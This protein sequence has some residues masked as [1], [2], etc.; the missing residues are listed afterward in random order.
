MRKSL[1]Q[2]LPAAMS[3]PD[4]MMIKTGCRELELTVPDVAKAQSFAG[5]VSHGPSTHHHHHHDSQTCYCDCPSHFSECSQCVREQLIARV[6]RHDDSDEEADHRNRFYIVNDDHQSVPNDNDCLVLLKS[7]DT[8]G[9]NAKADMHNHNGG[10]SDHNLKPH[11][12]HDLSG[13]NDLDSSFVKTVDISR[14]GGHRVSERL[15]QKPLSG[16]KDL[17]QIRDFQSSIKTKSFSRDRNRTDSQKSNDVDIFSAIFVS[18]PNRSSFHNSLPKGAM[19]QYIHMQKWDSQG[20]IKNAN[21]SRHHSGDNSAKRQQVGV[22]N[23]TSAAAMVHPDSEEHH[24]VYDGA[25]LN[26]DENVF[27]DQDVVETAFCNS[28]ND[29]TA[30]YGIFSSNPT[31][32]VCFSD[33]T[34]SPI[35]SLTHT[36][37]QKQFHPLT[38][39]GGGISSC[40]NSKSNSNCLNAERHGL[41]ESCIPNPVTAMHESKVEAYCQQM[42]IQPRRRSKSYTNEGCE[43]SNTSYHRLP[44]SGNV[45]GNDRPVSLEEEASSGVFSVES[46]NKLQTE[47]EVK[48]ALWERRNEDEPNLDQTSGS[49][50]Q[51]K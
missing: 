37:Q 29:N 24:M 43:Y 32:S 40:I 22:A 49:R 30:D 47:A 44:S 6:Q 27:S 28:K 14:H 34:A 31:E 17:S 7:N 20:N 1:Q 13:R 26:Q 42:Q 4:V 39:H 50:S 11:L 10:H 8:A 19:T 18:P 23:T 25:D 38:N 41:K 33:T 9:Y 46:P 48:R 45:N 2:A 36:S 12:C 15:K 51:L 16:Q 3:L 35:V 21:P 5:R